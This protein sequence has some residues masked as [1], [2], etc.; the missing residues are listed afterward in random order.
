MKVLKAKIKENSTHYK[1]GLNQKGKPVWLIITAFNP[2][3]ERNFRIKAV[4]KF[5]DGFALYQ[6]IWMSKDE[7][8]LKHIDNDQLSLDLYSRDEYDMLKYSPAVFNKCRFEIET[9]CEKIF[10]H[11][12]DLEMANKLAVNMGLSGYKIKRVR[13][14]TK[15][16]INEG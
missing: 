4:K 11:A 10:V 13:N 16:E 9:A 5:V 12:P 3:G 1:R 8:T 15:K 14:L 2:N 6:E 7:I